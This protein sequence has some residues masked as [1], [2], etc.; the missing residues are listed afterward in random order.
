ML[1]GNPEKRKKIVWNE[2]LENAFNLAKELITSEPVLAMFNPNQHCY[3]FTDGS[4]IGI[5]G[6]LKQ[7]DENGDLK[8]IGYFSRKLLDYQRNYSSIEFESL[9]IC[10][11]IKY[12]NYYLYGR[13]FTVIIITV[14]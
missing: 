11:S 13:E 8:P 9:A 2:Q 6:V 3:L 14:S 10:E 12:F 1:K 7:L 5:G 4:K